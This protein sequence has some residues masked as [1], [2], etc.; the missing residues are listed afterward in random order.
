[1]EQA[2][3]AVKRTRTFGGTGTN[4]DFWH[5]AQGRGDVGIHAD[6]RRN[7]GLPETRVEA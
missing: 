2:L 7:D 1:M 3:F 5:R 4:W 6:R